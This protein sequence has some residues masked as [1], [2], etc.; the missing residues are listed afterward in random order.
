[1]I[2]QKVQKA[3]LELAAELDAEGH[4][5][6]TAA[7]LQT[8]VFNYGEPEGHVTTCEFCSGLVERERKQNSLYKIGLQ[9]PTLRQF[10][11][12]PE[13]FTSIE[14]VTEELED[15]ERQLGE[16]FGVTENIR[17]HLISLDKDDK[18]EEDSLVR[19]WHQ[20]YSC[21]INWSKDDEHD[22]QLPE[23]SDSQD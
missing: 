3:L 2:T 18:L 16:R 11:G 20:V 7:E 17:E 15:I 5:H 22:D 6:L 1:M 13:Y 4:D 21:Y 23:I 14:I 19:D 12:W 8:A 10:D 9:S